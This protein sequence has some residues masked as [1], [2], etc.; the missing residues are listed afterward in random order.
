[1]IRYV[2]PVLLFASVLPA[3]AQAPAG[4][5][6]LIERAKIFGNPSKSGGKISPDGRWLSWIA[7]RDGVLNVWV[8]PA[9]DPSQARP[10]TQEKL[11]PIRSS[12]WSP[13]ST[14]LLF[15]QDKGGDENFLL[16]GVN[17]ASGKQI[18][19]TP[20]EK[21]RVRVIQISS[22]VK[23]RILIGINNRDARWHDVYSL[24]LASGKLTLVQRNDGYGGYVAD[25][26]LNLRIA[27]KARGDGGTAYYRVTDGKVE[28]TPLADVGL[29]DAQTTAPL[30]FTAD[31][32]TLYWTDSR[33]RNTSALLAQDVASGKSTLV[34]QDARADISD[35]LYD[36]RTGR[37]QAYAVEYLQ[38]DY[39]PL[40]EDLKDDLA[41]LKKH[42]PGQFTVTSRTDA[43]D[44]WL[45]AVDAVTA[46]VSSWLYER[47]GRKLTRLYVT[48]PELE[49]APLMP[50]HAQEI[51]ARDGLTLVS[52]LTL[53]KA[54]A[55]GPGGVPARPVP[56]VLL[57]HGGPW[58]RD[59]YGYNGYHQWLANRGYAVLSV[60]FRGSTGFGKQFISAGDL[61]WGRK[62][63]DDL[64]DAVQ[65]AVQSGVTTADKVAIMG[66][67]YGGYATLAGMAFTPTTFACGV[68]I[69]GPS[70]LFTLLQTIPPYWEAG[71]QRF[72]KRMGDPNTEE[73][74][75]LLKE[76]SPLNFAQNIQRPLLIGQ[77]AND[78]RVNVAESDQI[79]AAM[80]AKNIPVTYVLF[81]DEGHGF[82]RPVNN[83][84]FNAVTENFLG[85][86]LDGRAEPIGATLKASTAQVKH[87]AGY[88]PG[89]QEA[90][91]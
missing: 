37:V 52:Y 56:M 12:F 45:V 21:T 91:R 49:G 13:D 29:E 76:R 22:K 63:H 34:A 50:M 58:A 72:Y 43:D 9:S 70:N 4:E 68:D 86:C 73:G 88:A 81:P 33:G 82:A 28:V 23:D 57:V 87:G 66:G 89:L 80:A 53:P 85:K 2:L 20:F 16:Y 27:S 5:V 71:K 30:A 55:A 47:K 24:E 26:L 17:V 42:T 69:V 41:F 44:K 40:G 7:P 90:M 64:L 78:P 14:T 19:Y 32:K 46:P 65:W 15:I 11:R 83:I 61:Q 38:Q 1:M 8:A 62:M 59:T 51:K 60:N 6:P 79:V 77:G 36:T 3:H 75:A 10:L 39:L 18:D 25:E 54:S 84:A 48:R 35:A 67:S 31:G 74:K